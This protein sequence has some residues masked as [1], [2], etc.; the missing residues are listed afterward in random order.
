MPFERA[1]FTAGPHRLGLPT[2]DGHGNLSVCASRSPSAIAVIDGF[3]LQR[4]A[5]FPASTPVLQ[6]ALD[7]GMPAAAGW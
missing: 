6:A 4:P 5:R 1:N 7:A 3:P 2:E